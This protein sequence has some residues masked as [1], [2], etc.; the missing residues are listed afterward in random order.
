MSALAAVRPG[1]AAARRAAASVG[2]SARAPVPSGASLGGG[3]TTQSGVPLRSTP[4]LTCMPATNGSPGPPRLKMNSGMIA[5]IT[6][7]AAISRA[8]S[9]RLDFT[10]KAAATRREG[11]FRVS[12]GG[13]GGARPP[14]PRS[15]GPC[16]LT[17]AMYAVNLSKRW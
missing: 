8:A 2:G 13:G 11:A 14:R 1:G 5:A 3:L 9:C 16:A 4:S 12:G 10:C 15:L 6:G 17:S 7:K